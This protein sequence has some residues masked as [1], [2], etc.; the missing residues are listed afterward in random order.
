M[1]WFET[2][3]CAPARVFSRFPGCCLRQLERTGQASDLGH[4]QDVEALRMIDSALQLIVDAPLSLAYSA[5]TLRLVPR[6][7]LAR[8][9]SW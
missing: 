1:L 3:H 5:R 9:R 2:I 6:R 4:T 8:A 7:V